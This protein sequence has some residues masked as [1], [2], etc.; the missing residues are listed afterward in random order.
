[1]GVQ[2]L[3]ALLGAVAVG[4]LSL[5]PRLSIALAGLTPPIPGDDT[6][7]PEHDNDIRAVRGHRA[8]TGLTAG[9]SAATALGSVLVAFGGRY[10]VTAAAVAFTAAVGLALLLRSRTYVSGR[11][12]TALSLGGFCCLAAMFVL[13]VARSPAHGGWVGVV[14]VGVGLAVL[15]PTTVH[16]P[17]AGRLVDA[18]EYG[19][20]AGVAPLALW[21]TGALDAVRGLGPM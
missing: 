2:A 5:T 1:M 13:V 4:M 21:L 8:L 16:S 7:H 12:R 19:A 11:C 18:I 6:E 3:G 15:I 10:S 9:C 20:L 17:A 14:A